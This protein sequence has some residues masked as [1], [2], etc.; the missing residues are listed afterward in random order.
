MSIPNIDL[1]ELSKTL[2]KSCD[3]NSMEQIFS[4]NGLLKNLEK[5]LIE[6]LLKCELTAHLGYKKK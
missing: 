4:T 6:C 2:I 1:S 5:A 3:I